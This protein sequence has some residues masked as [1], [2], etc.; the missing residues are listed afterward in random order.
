MAAAHTFLLVDDNE[1]NR[2]LAG[3]ALRKAFPGSRIVETDQISEAL[4]MARELRPDG[5]LTDHHLGAQCGAG[6]VDALHDEG[7]DCPVVMVT[8]S[9]DPA[10]HERAYVSGAARVF[11]GADFDFVG[12]FRTYFDA[13]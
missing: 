13:R 9:V 2:F 3:Y 12:F 10:V 11:A 8:A 7:I 1:D 5:I 6:F 4:R